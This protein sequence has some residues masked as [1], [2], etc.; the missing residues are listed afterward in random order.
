MSN[1]N[2]NTFNIDKITIRA[3]FLRDKAQSQNLAAKKSKLH[4]NLPFIFVRVKQTK[5]GSRKTKR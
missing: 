3:L 4:Q 1:A 5:H 2:Y